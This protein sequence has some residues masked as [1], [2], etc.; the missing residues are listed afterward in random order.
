MNCDF[1][2]FTCAWETNPARRNPRLMRY[3]HST[4]LTETQRATLCIVYIMSN[5]DD[6]TVNT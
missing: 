1:L 6:Q 2:S 4:T 3:L 5:K